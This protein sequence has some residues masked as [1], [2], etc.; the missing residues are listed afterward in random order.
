MVTIAHH[1][2]AM[3]LCSAVSNV[4]NAA[5]GISLLNATVG[6]RC[7]SPPSDES[8]QCSINRQTCC[9][10]IAMTVRNL[11]DF[12]TQSGPNLLSPHNRCSPAVGSTYQICDMHSREWA[13]HHQPEEDQHSCSFSALPA[14]KTTPM[15][16]L[17]L[18]EQRYMC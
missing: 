10:R 16:V 1:F 15:T 4:K 8:L 9:K 11:N 2:Q 5:K 14:V 18:C 17:T 12:W 13:S 3:N 7:V 6:H